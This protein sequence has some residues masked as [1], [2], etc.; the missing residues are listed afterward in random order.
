MDPRMVVEENNVPERVVRAVAKDPAPVVEA[1]VEVPA[2]SVV[3]E[4]KAVEPSTEEVA[5]QA[6]KT[7]LEL[8][9]EYMEVKLSSN[10]RLGLPSVIHVRDYTGEDALKLASAASDTVLETLLGIVRG[11]V[12]EPISPMDLHE[13]DLKEILINI[14]LNFWG[15]IM[16]DYFYPFT[17]EEWEAL[18]AGRKELLSEGKEVLKTDIDLRKIETTVLPE[19]VKEPIKISKGNIQ[20]KFILPRVGHALFAEKYV[21]EKFKFEEEKYATVVAQLRLKEK[22]NNGDENDD[23]IDPVVKS[24]YADYQERKSALFMACVQSQLIVE[25]NGLPLRTI[26]DKIEVYKKLGI[27]FWSRYNET[28]EKDAKFGINSEVEMLS[29]IS[30]ETVKRRCSFQ[31]VEFIPS[32]KLSRLEEFDVCFGGQ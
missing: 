17:D 18:P 28:V 9:P 26:E 16:E 1:P 12:Y 5:R 3:E 22:H 8:P 14:H 15:P 32:N 21:A 23:F 11:M 30:N 20:V 31:F 13:E 29:P 19:N 27:Q 10:G 4:P 7:A 2:A 25:Y 6:I 24:E